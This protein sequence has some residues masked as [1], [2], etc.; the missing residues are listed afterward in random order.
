MQIGPPVPSLGCARRLRRS[1]RKSYL[2]PAKL[3][4]LCLPYHLHLLE[5]L[6]KTSALRNYT[7]RSAH[8]GFRLINTLLVG[9]GLNLQPDS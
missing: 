5:R 1:L 6:S 4:V 2:L 8:R 3:P 7:I 9:I